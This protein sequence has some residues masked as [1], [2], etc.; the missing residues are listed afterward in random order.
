M[1]KVV[2]DFNANQ[3]TADIQYEYEGI[4]NALRYICQETESARLDLVCLHL[5]IAIE[6]LK[7]YQQPL[8]KTGS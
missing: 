7:E 1:N 6:E 4:I 8:A 3:Y 2:A 5:N